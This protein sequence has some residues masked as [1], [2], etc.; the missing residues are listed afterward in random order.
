ML[1]YF[2]KDAI[3]EWRKRVGEEEANKITRQ[4]ATRGT[5]LHKIV[6]KFLANEDMEIESPTQLALFKSII[7]YLNN[8]DNI[9]LQEKYLYSDHLRL[10]GTVDCIAEYNGKLNVIDFKSSSKPKREDWIEGYFVQ[11]TAYAIMFEERYK[12]PVPRITIMIAVENDYPQ[13][14]QKKRDEYAGKLLKMRDEYEW[15]T[16]G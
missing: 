10:A 13:I 11:A 1:S 7:P 5:R 9:Y 16:K 3:K 12:I 8:I 14:F 2:S 4:A 15:S 6:E